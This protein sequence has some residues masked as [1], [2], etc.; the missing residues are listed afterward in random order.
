MCLMSDGWVGMSYVRGMSYEVFI[1]RYLVLV[2]STNEA[3][4]EEALG[5]EWYKYVRGTSY[6]VLV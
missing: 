6:E 3:S 2:H 5:G 1:M 4:S